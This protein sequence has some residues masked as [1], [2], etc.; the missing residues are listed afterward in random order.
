MVLFAV[1]V[2]VAVNLSVTREVP[3]PAGS[4][5]ADTTAE[6]S[7]ER[8]TQKVQKLPVVSD[9]WPEPSGEEVAAT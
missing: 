7:G 3:A 2:A 8:K 4:R 9:D 5:S 6:P 1:A